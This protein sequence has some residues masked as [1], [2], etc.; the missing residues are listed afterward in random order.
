[1]SEQT[2]TT[3]TQP[4]EELPPEAELSFRERLSAFTEATRERSEGLI[5]HAVHASK[6]AYHGLAAGVMRARM[7]RSGTRMERMH[8]KME[9]YSDLGMLAMTGKRGNGGHGEREVNG[10]IVA[11]RS[12]LE[13]IADRHLDRKKQSKDLAKVYAYRAQKN[14]G[15]KDSLPGLNDFERKTLKRRIDKNKSLSAQEK[16]LRKGEVDAQPLKLGEKIH[17]RTSA[18]HLAATNEFNSTMGVLQPGRYKKKRDKAIE[19]IK[20]RYKKSETHREAINQLRAQRLAEQQ[21]AEDTE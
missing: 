20:V 1:M 6:V 4:L 5:D 13:R 12:I 14:F 3:Q 19:K 7:E 8:H 16:R 10:D 2:Q 15:P 9:L 11:P 21:L 17:A 18:D